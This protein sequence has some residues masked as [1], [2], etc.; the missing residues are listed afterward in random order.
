MS[1]NFKS[2]KTG[3]I[4]LGAWLAP[5]Y[6]MLK[7]KQIPWRPTK[8]DQPSR[9][10]STRLVS[11]ISGILEDAK[12]PRG[13]SFT[14]CLLDGRV[15]QPISGIV[16]EKD[17]NVSIPISHVFSQDC[18]GIFLLYNHWKITLCPKIAFP[19]CGKKW[20]VFQGKCKSSL[21]STVTSNWSWWDGEELDRDLHD[22]SRTQFR[23]FFRGII[24]PS[25]HLQ[26]IKSTNLSLWI[27]EWNLVHCPY[28]S[29]FRG[30]EKKWKI[31][32]SKGKRSYK[33]HTSSQ[34]CCRIRTV[35]DT[36]WAKRFRYLVECIL[37]GIENIEAQ[38]N[39]LI[40][41]CKSTM[42]TFG[43]RIQQSWE[44]VLEKSKVDCFSQA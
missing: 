37:E 7:N 20:R 5:F 36:S 24:E 42:P 33:T 25:Y 3:R 19:P 27:A 39:L 10:S 15:L 2:T 17:L 30:T 28:F 18:R 6:Q 14:K 11:K 13:W 12:G 16:P 21:S 29:Q 35:K 43:I 38:L 9:N 23:S 32:R 31:V 1:T 8:C 44:I 26:I 40:P 34:T 41:W 4:S 22:S